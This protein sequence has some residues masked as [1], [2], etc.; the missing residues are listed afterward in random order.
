MRMLCAIE[1]DAAAVGENIERLRHRLG[2]TQAGL[3][4]RARLSRVTVSRIERGHNMTIKDRTL[5]ALAKALGT[6]V[7]ELIG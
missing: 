1:I 2:W 4:K 6:N 3:A 7:G 5:D